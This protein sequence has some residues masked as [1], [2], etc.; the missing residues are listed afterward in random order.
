[1]NENGVLIVE[2]KPVF[3]KSVRRALEGAV[4]Q[5]DFTEAGSIAEGLTMLVE[6]SN[7]KV[8]LLDL[9]LPDGTGA[10]FLEQ[11]KGSISEYRIIV[12]TGR[13]EKLAADVAK[14]HGVFNYLAKAQ[15]SF[16]Q[17]IRFTVTQAFADLER[18]QLK[19]KNQRLFHIHERINSSIKESLSPADMESALDDVLGLICK[20]VRKLVGVHTCHIRVYDLG[21]GDFHL[22]AFSGPDDK[23]RGIFGV[24]VRK[25]EFFSGK[26]AEV[27][28]PLSFDD[29]QNNEEFKAFRDQRL[30]KIMDSGDELLLK[31]AHEYFDSI[32]SAFIVPIT[33]RMFDGE[34]DAV[35]NV[36]SRELS[37]FFSDSKQGVINEFVSLATTAISKVWQ[38]KRKQDAHEGNKRISK[39]LEDIS[40]ELGREDIEKQIYS[41]AVKGV[42]D[43]INPETISI[44][45][46]NK[47]THLL[48]NVAEYRGDEIVTPRLKGHPTA[49]GL[50]GRV[51]TMREALRIPNLQK[52]DTRKP[53]E[54]PSYNKAL[55]N[56]YIEHI[57]SGRVD[58]YL[59]VP[60][61]IGDEVV[62]AIQL[63]NKKSAYYLDPSID[64]KRW[65]LERGFSEDCENVLGI[66]AGYL[67]VAIKNAE[68]IGE[69][70]KKISQ[71]E[72][73]KDVG[74][75][76]TDELPIN[77][78]LEKTIQ[79]AAEDIQAEI[80]LLFLMNEKKNAVVLDQSYGIPQ[81]YL[82]NAYYAI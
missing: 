5:Y 21:K 22:A 30:A 70:D 51:F 62:G 24:P 9:D 44:F 11:I 46:L 50:T 36:S 20:S 53:D 37:T 58:H 25:D 28:K 48:D 64:K 76:I 56:D 13:D 34:I 27:K 3:R 77:Q 1:M 35:F 54:H 66:A 14:E 18:E 63:L 31:R 71:L 39:V 16:T 72:T 23:V 7:I 45:L 17:S 75:Y 79:E 32:Q 15:G 80:C 47:T 49:E 40:K 12:L 2:D 57:P 8:I 74:R 33:T 38:K 61:I 41:I 55:G 29:L 26:V 19:D 69:R 73:L 42:A 52:E 10:D 68:L 65:L 59:G 43:I 81:E 60:M 4:V 82:P 78:L 67:A 6:H